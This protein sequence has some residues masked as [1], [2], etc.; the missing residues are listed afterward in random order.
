MQDILGDHLHEFTRTFDK[1]YKIAGVAPGIKL[2]EF[3]LD[4]LRARSS[5]ETCLLACVNKGLKTTLLQQ[6][7]LNESCKSTTHSIEVAPWVLFSLQTSLQTSLDAR[8]KAANAEEKAPDAV[9][10]KEQD[11]IEKDLIAT[12]I[13]L[14]QRLPE[15][16]WQEVREYFSDWAVVC[17]NAASPS[18]VDSRIF[19]EGLSALASKSTYEIGDK[20][21][22]IGSSIKLYTQRQY[23]KC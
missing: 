6:T 1:V 18:E 16:T 15:E 11:L 9:V 3:R 7:S 23:R 5:I 10:E 20:H 19:G 12:S 14:D 21:S 17:K 22:G 8:V 4:F 13:Q 2:L